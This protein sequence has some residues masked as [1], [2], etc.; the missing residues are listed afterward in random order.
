MIHHHMTLTI[1]FTM[2]MSSYIEILVSSAEAIKSKL[3][4]LNN[5]ETLLFLEYQSQY[6]QNQNQQKPVISSTYRP[7]IVTTVTTTTQTPTRASSYLTSAQPT[8]QQRPQE[9]QTQYDDYDDA[10]VAQVDVIR[11]FAFIR[12][13]I[14]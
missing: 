10:L 13:F 7:T 8:Y 9:I 11:S 14:W 3:I 1:P 12:L 5:V 4:Y 6:N 2:M